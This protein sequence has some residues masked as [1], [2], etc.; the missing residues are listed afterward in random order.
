M[1][2]A[3]DGVGGASDSEGLAGDDDDEHAAINAAVSVAADA[4]KSFRPVR[5]MA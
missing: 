3:P 2:V 4:C 1:A 5:L